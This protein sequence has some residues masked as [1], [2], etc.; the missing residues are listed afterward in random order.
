MLD[1]TADVTGGAPASFLRTLGEFD[2]SAH[3]EQTR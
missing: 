2:S 3:S 1:A